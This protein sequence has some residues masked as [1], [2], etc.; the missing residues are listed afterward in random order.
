MLISDATAGSNDTADSQE[1]VVEEV[2]LSQKSNTQT[3]N[4]LGTM[5]F[6]YLAS[7]FVGI[8]LIVV[9]LKQLQARKLIKSQLSWQKTC[10]KIPCNS[11]QYFNNNIYMKCAVQP[12]LVLSEK[13]QDCPDYQPPIDNNS[14]SSKTLP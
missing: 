1:S 13:A 4:A 2:P 7:G 9:L 3:S 8:F 6:V 11:C 5:E 12:T 14:D 10:Q